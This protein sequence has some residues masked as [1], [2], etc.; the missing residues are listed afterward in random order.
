[1][2]VFIGKPLLSILSDESFFRFFASFLVLAKITTS[3][4]R[5]KL[6]IK[7][8]SVQKCG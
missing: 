4:I 7:Y 8:K 2:F 1:M 6:V 5:V 3:S